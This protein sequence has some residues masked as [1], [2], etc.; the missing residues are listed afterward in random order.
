MAPTFIPL[1]SPLER[2]YS[3]RSRIPKKAK[4]IICKLVLNLCP[5]FFQSRLCFS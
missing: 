4:M 5:Q 3:L 1:G 2:V